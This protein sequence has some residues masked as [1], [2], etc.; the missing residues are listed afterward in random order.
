VCTKVKN[1]RTHSIFRN[2]THHGQ[3]AHTSIVGQNAA[4]YCNLKKIQ[5]IGSEIETNLEEK[6]DFKAHHLTNKNIW[7]ATSMNMEK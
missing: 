3:T 1:S 2:W 4:S 5:E 6:V 7:S